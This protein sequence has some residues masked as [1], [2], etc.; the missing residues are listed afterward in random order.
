MKGGRCLVQYSRLQI[1]VCVDPTPVTHTEP[2]LIDLRIII[3]LLTLPE[4]LN[5]SDM[6]VRQLWQ[7]AGVHS[8]GTRLK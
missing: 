4:Y 5:V 1:I 8:G 2:T 3:T 6:S 7:L